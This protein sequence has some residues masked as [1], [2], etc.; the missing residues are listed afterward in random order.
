MMTNSDR[1]GGGFFYPTL[2]R[3]M[4]SFSC[5]RLFLFIYL[6]LYFFIFYYFKNKLPEVPEFAKMQ[7]HMMLL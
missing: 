6:F 5:S 3:I 4:D 2:T 7:F 1:E